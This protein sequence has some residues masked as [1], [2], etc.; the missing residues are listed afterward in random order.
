MK[1]DRLLEQNLFYKVK[2]IV[3]TDA[4][5]TDCTLII[6]YSS[7]LR[8]VVH[9]LDAAEETDK[10][11]LPIV[12]VAVESCDGNKPL[13]LGNKLSIERNMFII[14][15]AGDDRGDM[16]DLCSWIR[17]KLNG[18][19]SIYD[20]NEGF[21]STTILGSYGINSEELE[22]EVLNKTSDPTFSANIGAR[23][24]LRIVGYLEFIDLEV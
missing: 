5:R 2:S 19:F 10:T 15:V 1:I 23:Y 18:E 7:E 3:E 21:L 11:P 22:W 14:E 16:K 6:G 20:Y 4:G 8:E 9:P 24:L 13:E 17:Q 12:S